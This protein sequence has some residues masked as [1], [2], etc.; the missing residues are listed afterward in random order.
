MDPSLTITATSAVSNLS[1]EIQEE[2]HL[3][4]VSVPESNLFSTKTK[5]KV[6]HLF[7]GNPEKFL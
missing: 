2:T 5:N 3:A 4:K 1:N 6:P 7:N